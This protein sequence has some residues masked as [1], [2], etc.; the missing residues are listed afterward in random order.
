M[1]LH[2]LGK[3]EDRFL[4]EHRRR[5]AYG[6]HANVLGRIEAHVLRGALLRRALGIA[7]H[8][9]SPAL[10]A[11]RLGHVIGD[12]VVLLCEA[13]G[14]GGHGAL[15]GLTAGERLVAPHPCG[16]GDVLGRT[17]VLDDLDVGA[18]FGGQAASRKRQGS[19]GP[20]P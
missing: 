10:G 12:V 5:P 7:L 6:G 14:D 1:L 15:Y 19:G 16:T 18:G 4:D 13:Q 17:A 3:G 8:E 11:D 9:H 20:N 2:L